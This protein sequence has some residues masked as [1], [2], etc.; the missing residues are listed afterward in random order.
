MYLKIIP[1]MMIKT[2]RQ[3]EHYPLCNLL[4]VNSPSLFVLIFYTHFINLVCRSCAFLHLLCFFVVH[5]NSP[6]V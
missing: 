5:L 1:D 3:C 6:V 2:L 4:Y